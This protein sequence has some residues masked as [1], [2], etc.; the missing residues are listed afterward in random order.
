MAYKIKPKRKDGR[1]LGKREWLCFRDI[2]NDG[3]GYTHSTLAHA[4]VFASMEEL[5][6][7]AVQKFLETAGYDYEVV[8]VSSEES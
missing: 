8:E 6:S 4:Y 7:E 5:N 3:G 2:N 1:P